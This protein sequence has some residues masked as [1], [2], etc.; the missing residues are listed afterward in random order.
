MRDFLVFL[1]D[2]LV[3]FVDGLV[4][5]C[6]SFIL[7]GK[8]TVKFLLRFCNCS[9]FNSL[10]QVAHIL[11]L[12]VDLS[13]HQKARLLSIKFLQKAVMLPIFFVAEELVDADIF[14]GMEN[15][16]LNHRIGF[17]QLCDD[18]LGFHSLVPGAG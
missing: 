17:L 1:V 2:G 9:G 7:L 11:N 18:A 15:V 10:A 5:L 3:L 16:A 14:G 8:N 6:D 4:F 12:P 13:C